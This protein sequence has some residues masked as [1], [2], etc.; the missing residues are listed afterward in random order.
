MP[1]STNG[2]SAAP[3]KRH[4]VFRCPAMRCEQ[5]EVGNVPP[6]NRLLRER[7]SARIVCPAISSTPYPVMLPIRLLAPALGSL[8]GK[9]LSRTREVSPQDA[10][11]RRL[12]AAWRRW[13]ARKIGRA[14]LA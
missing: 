4:P 10:L 14:Y 9:S 5:Q 7:L 11:H 3:Q 12:L 13:G 1:R 8:A 6:A 2:C